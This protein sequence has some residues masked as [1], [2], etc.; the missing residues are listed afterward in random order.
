M[1]EYTKGVWLY[2]KDVDV[3]KYFDDY[4]INVANHQPLIARVYG[5]VDNAKRICQCVNNF[6]D[7]LEVCKELYS[8]F[9]HKAG[10]E[11]GNKLK[12]KILEACPD[13]VNKL[14]NTRAA[15]AKATNK[16]Q[17]DMNL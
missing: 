11:K 17:V 4:V 7:L 2:R 14:N 16:S 1:A 8:A 13:I 5:S 3:V 15:I 9:A 12:T 10:D 6:D